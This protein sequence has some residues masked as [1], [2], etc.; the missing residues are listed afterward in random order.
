MKPDKAP[1]G[2]LCAVGHPS[3]GVVARKNNDGIWA[4]LHNGQAVEHDDIYKSMMVLWSPVVPT[5]CHWCEEEHEPGKPMYLHATSTHAAQME[6]EGI[7]L[8]SDPPL[9]KS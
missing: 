2:T 7:I 8:S 6:A 3:N 9:L 1:V 5:K 4:Y